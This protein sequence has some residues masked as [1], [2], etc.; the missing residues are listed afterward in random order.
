[1]TTAYIH[2]G[3]EKTGSTA[4]QRFLVDNRDA[5]RERGLAYPDFDRR[6]PWVDKNVNG[7]WLTEGGV[8]SRANRAC[9]KLIASEAR[10]VGAVVVSAETLW[11]TQ[12][13]RPS[14]WRELRRALPK[15]VELRAIAY[16]RRQ[17]DYLFSLWSQWVKSQNADGIEA[18][19]FLE[20][21]AAGRFSGCRLDYRETLSVASDVLGVD[22]IIVRPYEQ[23]QFAGGSI[24]TDFLDALSIPHDDSLVLPPCLSNESLTG[25]VLEAKRL[26]NATDD[27]KG[28]RSSIL[29]ELLTT[30]HRLQARGVLADHGTLA[31]AE[32][33]RIIAPYVDSNAWVARTFLGR[34]DGVLFREPY[35]DV[36]PELSAAGALE[37]AGT[38]TNEELAVVYG[39][40]VVRLRRGANKLED[41][42][43]ELRSR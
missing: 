24:F 22:N 5:L 3:T 39:E 29:R 20:T 32:R 40:L 17:D 14:F 38:F 9:M 7:F 4:I 41:E 8:A 11:T 34:A 26:L 18:R 19:T 2:I 25:A 21:E 23:A 6:Y 33:E 35:G 10:S 1:M 30:Q 36:S 15:D 16:L 27:L 31:T 37:A 43:A 12:A 42:L 13:H 28:K